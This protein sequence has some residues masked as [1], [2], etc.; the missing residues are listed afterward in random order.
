M[1]DTSALSRKI[2]SDI[3][4]YSKYARYLPKLK[5]RETWSEIVTRNFNTHF[6]K[7]KHLGN[8]FIDLIAENN[9]YI[10]EKKVFPSMRFA[11]FAGKPIE[12]N[13]SRG[14]NCSYAP[15]DHIDVF[16]EAMFL[17]LSGCGFSFSVQKHHVEKL[18]EIKG[19]TRRKRNYLIG[20]S[21]IGW[22]DA[23]KQLIYAYFVGKSDPVFKYDDI[24]E[25][26][27]ILIT[28]G[29][30][31]PGPQPLKDCI[32][33]I[34]K[35]LDNAITER[36]IGTKLTPIECHDLLCFIADA[37]LSGGIRRAA[38]LSGFSYDDDEM[39]A[40]KTNAWFELHSERQRSNNSVVL[41]RRKLNKKSFDR[42]FNFIQ[43]SQFGEPGI[44]LTHDKDY[45]FNPC[46]AGDTLIA[47]ADGRG[48]VSIKDL[49]SSG[50]DV[51]VYSVNNNGKVSIKMGRNPRKT[52]INRD[53]VKI[54][55]D[56]NSFIK[57]T[58]DHEMILRNGTRIKA[59]DLKKGDSL[60]RFTKK[61]IKLS[62]KNNNLYYRIHCDTRDINNDRILEHRLIAKFNNSD[63]WDNI[64][65]TSK[66]NGW[67][68]GGLVVH[69]KDYN[70]LNNSPDN[71]EIMSFK[72][73]TNFHFNCDTQGLKNGRFSGYSNDQLK[74]IA[75]N[76]TKKLGRRFSVNE[77]TNADKN[78]P[79]KFSTWRQKNFFRSPKE[80]AVW[81]AKECELFHGCDIRTEKLYIKAIEQGYTARIISN[82]VE[83]LKTCEQCKI[84]FYVKYHKREQSFCSMRCA[85][86]YN[87][88]KHGDILKASK[89]K[90]SMQEQKRNKQINIYNNLKLELGRDPMKKEW[91]TQCK[92]NNI[93]HRI[94]SKNQPAYKNNPY[95]F[96][97][98]KELKEYANEYNHKV[99]KVEFLTEKEDVYNITVD[100]NHTVGIVTNSKNNNYIGIFS[101][102]CGE[103]SLRSQSF[104]NLTTI[105]CDDITTQEEF[106]KRARC[107][108][109]FGTLQASYTDF[110]YL[111]DVWRDNTEKDYLIGVSLTGI[112]TKSFLKLDFREAANI[113]LETNKEIASIIGI[114]EAART[115]LTKPEGTTSCVAGTSS[116]VHAWHS[117]YYIRRIRLNKEEPL[118]RYL[119]RAIPNLIEDDIFK[120]H[121]QAVISIPI[122][123][124]EDA[125]TRDESAIE[126]I[127]RCIKLTDEWIIPG[128]RRGA[129]THNVSATIT[130]KDDE[131]DQVKAVVWENIDR[132]NGM[133]F[134]KYD[135]GNYPQAP[136]S[137]C[138]EEEYNELLDHCR[139]IDLTKVKEELDNTNLNEQSACS[140][141]NC[142]VTHM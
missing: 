68:D 106:N 124:P 53:L 74:V 101:C 102:Q 75:I 108:A 80:L 118:Y 122:K 32:H 120:P 65:D 126:L 70:G 129:N 115:T 51:P 87:T 125:I 29:G 6:K 47:V 5:R 11:Q 66:C 141:G 50:L 7:F 93:S 130:V 58:H 128:H 59:K 38:C 63:K 94:A 22:S 86:I 89:K 40:A 26:G 114:N 54:T 132:I 16:S 131:W 123:A 37:V 97:S 72:E 27:A 62:D 12:I 69:H 28:S 105:V 57:I 98:F 90:I 3:T 77:W 67:I 71:L 127:K 61:A 19:P 8:D 2:L 43:A 109:I 135:G 73:H 91:E 9:Q 18:P 23:I 103:A 85:G 52:G 56:D 25:K 21:I 137:E 142:T 13:N 113:V 88:K 140:G 31:A 39:M 134:F 46:F 20:D 111:R 49:S 36:G 81:A 64:Y 79:T 119:K 55:L 48:A 84:N 117:K 35:V 83:V 139:G 100:D 33:N 136:F 104:C 4:I 110:H 99:L 95:A 30:K 78:I 24:R 44:L 76:L 42:I 15:V 34:R 96:F 116:G 45:L 121:I 107:A 112:A 133:T 41:L 138:S 92:I 14:Y 10:M 82:T 60:C 17:L 1:I